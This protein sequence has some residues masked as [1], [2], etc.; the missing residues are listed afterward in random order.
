MKQC[1]YKTALLLSFTSLLVSCEAV[2]APGVEAPIDTQQFKN[3]HKQLSFAQQFSGP[4]V[5]LYFQG[6]KVNLHCLN[7]DYHSEKH[8]SGV[9]SL[10]FADLPVGAVLAIE[11]THPS[12]Q[13]STRSYFQ[14]PDRFGDIVIYISAEGL[15]FDDKLLPQ[16]QPENIPPLPSAQH[17]SPPTIPTSSP[18]PRLPPLPSPS[19][20]AQ[21]GFAGAWALQG[22]TPDNFQY[23]N[24]SGS[25]TKLDGQLET[26]SQTNEQVDAFTGRLENIQ[27]Q[28]NQL[29][30]RVT[31]RIEQ[32]QRLPGDSYVPSG[33]PVYIYGVIFELQLHKDT[34]GQTLQGTLTM[35]HMHHQALPGLTPMPVTYQRR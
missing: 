3:S 10:N 1:V 2:Q 11:V 15:Y 5:G 8:F 6:L 35:S 21:T 22:S 31:G 17:S 16:Q 7:C 23:L 33:E 4:G 13:N 30:A 28:D 20:E 12:S 19:A 25:E 27:I 14:I 18:T 32:R 29:R 26:R 9:P 34:D 24:L